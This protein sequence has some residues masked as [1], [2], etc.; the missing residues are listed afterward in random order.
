MD[1]KT[2]SKPPAGGSALTTFG[3]LREERRLDSLTRSEEFRQLLSDRE[4]NRQI[5]SAILNSPDCERL[6][7]EDPT[8][9]SL[10]GLLE[11]TSVKI[12]KPS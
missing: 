12:L 5:T 2:S 8:A 10:I 11:S 6:L 3:E 1:T 4:V 7:T 9:A